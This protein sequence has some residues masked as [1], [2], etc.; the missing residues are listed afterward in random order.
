MSRA[1]KSTGWPLNKFTYRFQSHDMSE[2]GVRAWVAEHL[3]KDPPEFILGW[4]DTEEDEVARALAALSKMFSTRHVRRAVGNAKQHRTW[5]R[6]VRAAMSPHSPPR[7]RRAIRSRR[8]GPRVGLLARE[9][10]THQAKG[11]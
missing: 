10:Q 11:Q 1:P 3:K 2:A 8:R 6:L 7:R 5:L 9:A 4:I